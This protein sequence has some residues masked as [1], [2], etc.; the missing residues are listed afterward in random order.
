MNESVV[1]ESLKNDGFGL[2][3][4]NFV[5][6]PL[7]RLLG[8]SSFAIEADRLVLYSPGQRREVFYSEIV[9]IHVAGRKI[10]V[11]DGSEVFKICPATDF[12]K[13]VSLIDHLRSESNA[14][15]T[16]IAA[17]TTLE[18]GFRMF[19]QCLDFRALPYVRAVN[20]LLKIASDNCFT[21]IHFE[22]LDHKSVRITFR[23][24][25]EV[26]RALTFS[27]THHGRLMARFKYLAGCL[28]HITDNA[29]EGAFRHTNF[30]VRLSTFPTDNGERASIRIITALRY[31]DTASLGWDAKTASLWINQIN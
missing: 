19:L 9:D 30:D 15:A 18:A 20:L 8:Y 14:F 31:P 5:P 13:V 4:I 27:Q 17:T 2:V 23:A 16:M 21:D 22:P 3:P 28:S 29:Q 24:A 12:N 10:I 1:T 11:S 7:K 26:K 25:G 6:G